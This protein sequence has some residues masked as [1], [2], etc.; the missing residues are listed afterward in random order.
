IY[1]GC[2]RKHPFCLSHSLLSFGSATARSWL[3]C[4]PFDRRQLRPSVGTW[5][6][7]TCIS[8]PLLLARLYFVYCAFAC[9]LTLALSHSRRPSLPS[10]PQQR[11]LHA[12]CC[13][14]SGQVVRVSPGLRRRSAAL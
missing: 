10:R 14:R 1:R 13:R 5:T 4:Q 7:F 8:L 2:V 12:G 9:A 11:G 6:T 3:M